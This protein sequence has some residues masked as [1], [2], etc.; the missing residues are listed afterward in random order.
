MAER[1]DTVFTQTKIEIADFH[2]TLFHFSGHPQ[3]A[4]VLPINTSSAY[5]DLYGKV[6]A[7]GKTGIDYQTAA[8]GRAGSI[9]DKLYSYYKK[10]KKKNFWGTYVP[11]DYRVACVMHAW[12]NFIPFSV[13]LLPKVKYLPV[14]KSG[15]KVS[16]LPRV[17][18][19]PFGWSTWLSFLIRGDLSLNGLSSLIKR[20]FEEDVFSL[21]DINTPLNLQDLCD[22]IAKGTRADAF[23]DLET[24]DKIGSEFMDIVTVLGKRAGSL[25]CKAWFDEDK[26]ALQR[27]VRPRHSPSHAGFKVNKIIEDNNDNYIAW[28]RFG[29][30][31]WLYH[32]LGGGSGA[33]EKLECYHRNTF[34]AFLLAWHQILLLQEG[35]DKLD[36]QKMPELNKLLRQAKDILSR[37]PYG[38]AGL[39]LLVQD[40]YV[41]TIL[42]D[43]S[44]K[45]DK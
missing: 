15:F 36:A 16:L 24:G 32:L 9:F 14:D 17:L 38:N 22:Y 33:Y 13:S 11:Y 4:S 7:A 41:N 26:L 42:A 37:R 20:V 45:L 2:T 21:P 18:L 5:C 44:K 12:D 43:A 31:I 28:D 40:K 1:N 27:I 6:F 39:R 23:A 10:D 3:T 8:Q 34:N 25:S 35:M 19:F 29:C 30:F